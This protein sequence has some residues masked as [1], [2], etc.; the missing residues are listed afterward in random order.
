MMA[1]KWTGAYSV[2]EIVEVNYPYA[3]GRRWVRAWVC[4]RSNSGYPIVQI[5][6]NGQP[7][8]FTVGRRDEIRVVL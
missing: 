3:D 1:P 4:E 8:T 7:H 6:A 2:G 5:P